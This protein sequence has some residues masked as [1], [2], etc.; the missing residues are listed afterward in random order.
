MT[1]KE[2][3]LDQLPYKDVSL[4]YRFWKRF[5]DIFISLFA[6]L[7]LALPLFI[8]WLVVRLSSPG[9]GIFKDERVG[10]DDKN[11]GVY[12]FRTMYADA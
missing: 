2:K 12:K 7:V 10:K 4:W 8:I 6:I 3:I 5:F 9:K 11:I 1:K